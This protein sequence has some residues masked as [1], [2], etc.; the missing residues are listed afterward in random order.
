ME[1]WWL[2]V[3]RQEVRVRE[4][5]ESDKLNRRTGVGGRDH[6]TQKH[7]AIIKEEERSIGP[8]QEV[9]QGQ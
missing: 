4:E 7:K 5:K 2:K 9:T 3:D 6:I 1:T 8:R